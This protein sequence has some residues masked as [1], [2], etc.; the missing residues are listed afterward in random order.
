MRDGRKWPGIGIGSIWIRWIRR[1]RRVR[2][3]FGEAGGKGAKEQTKKGGREE[4]R[5][6]FTRHME[7]KLSEQ[8]EECRREFQVEI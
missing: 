2:R 1:M 3:G 8:C 7:M 6:Q 4:S 5:Q